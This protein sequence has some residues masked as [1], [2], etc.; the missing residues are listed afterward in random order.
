MKISSLTPR[1]ILSS[2]IAALLGLHLAPAVHA[3]TL[4]WDNG[5]A[6]GNWNT[7]DTNWTGSIWNNATPDNAIFNNI[8]GTVTLTQAITGGTLTY[9]NG[10]SPSGAHELILTGSN[11]SLASIL[12][13]GGYN[14][15]LGNGG[16]DSIG[17]AYNQRLRL[18]NITVATSGNATARRGM[19]YLNNATL[20]VGG[21]I[22]CADA[23]NVFREDNSTVTATGGIDLSIIASQV[24]LYGGTV[25]TPFVKVGNAAFNGTGGLFM[26]GGVTLVPTGASSDYLAVFNNGDVNNRAGATITSGGMTIDTAYAVTVATSLGGSGSLAKSGNGSLTLTNNNSYT[27]GTTVNSGV[28]EVS[29]SSGGNG[30]IRGTATVNAGGELRFTGGDGTGFGYNGGNRIDT[31]NINGGLVHSVGSA[32]L[33]NGVNVN[34]T[35]GELRVTSGTVQWNYVNVT[36]AASAST[37]LINAAINFRGDGGFTNSI[38]NVADGAAATDLEVTGPIT[39]S[40]GTVGLTKNGPGTMKLTGANSYSG[41]T[42]I[43]DGTLEI[44]G[45]AG[46]LGSGGVTNYAALLFNRSTALTVGNVISGS[47]SVT[48]SGAGTITLTGANS[49][50]GTTTINVGTTLE[51]GGSA[52]SLGSG[53][54]VNDGA[55][56]FNR[57][58]ALSDGNAISGTGSVTQSGAGIT[59]LSGT[60]TYTGAT[61]VTA[62]GLDLIGSLTSN[63]TVSGG[64]LSGEGSTTGSLTLTGAST[65]GFDPTTGTYLSAASV[66]AT[67]GTVTLVPAISTLG[68]GIVV[69]EAVGGITGV[70]GT[71]FVFTG[72]GTSYLN[73]GNTQLLFD[74]TPGSVVWTGDDGT[75]PT[76]WDV[77]TTGNWTLGGNPDL[78][79]TG[80]SVTFDDT[81]TSFNVAVQGASLTPGGV[82]FDN[83]TAYTVSGGAIAGAGGLTKNNTGTVTIKSAQTF[84]GATVINAGTLQLGDG[85]G[86]ND[87]SL[88]TSGITNDGTLAYNLNGNQTVGYAISGTGALTK[89]GAG[90][91][92]LT[93]ANS[94]T[95][96]TTVSGGVL[97]AGIASAFGDSSGA[98]SVASGGSLDVNAQQLDG[99]TQNIQIAGSGSDAALGALGNH[100]A[101]NLNAVRGLTLTGNASIGGNGGRWDIGRLDW[102]ADPNNTVNHING[103][104]FVLTKVGSSELG[105][106]CG[107][108]NL[109]GFVLNAGTIVPH[110]NTAF[111]TAP[112]TINAGLFK[113]WAGLTLANNFTLN[114]GTIGTDAGFNDTYTG[115]FAINAAVTFNP[116]N[117]NI[118]LTGAVDGAGNLNKTGSSRLILSGNNTQTGTL[119]VSG[120]HVQFASGTGNAT[121]GNVE[122]LNPGSFLLMN[123]PNQFGPN[124]GLLFNSSGGH[125]EF[126]LYGNNQTIASLAS[127]N[128]FAVVQNSHG[129]F[130][131]A[132][133]S[134]TLTVNQSTDTTYYGVFRDN[135][136]NDAFTL[137]L[138]K[139]G[140][141]KLTLATNASHTGGTTV[142]GGVLEVAGSSGG[143]GYIR[144]TATVNVGGELRFSGGDGTGFGYNNGNRIDTLNILGGLVHSTTTAH[145]FNGVNVNMTGGEL[146]VS[147][148]NIQW[149]FVTVTTAASASTALI[150]GALNFRG[151]GGFSSSIFNV[152]D[153]A[154]AADLEVNGPI[155]QLN[156]NVGLTKN[157]TGTMVLS[158]ANSYGGQ[159]QINAG[160]LLVTNSTGLGVGGH[161]GTTMTFIQDGAT[162]ALQGGISLDEHFHVWGAGVGGL[163]A[164]RSISGNN[165]LTNAPGGGPGYALRSDT[166]VGVEAD[167]LTVSGFY[168]GDAGSYGLIKIGAGTLTLTAASTYT[169]TTTVSGGTLELA[170]VNAVQAS[171]LDT[172]T[173][174]AQSVTFTVA[175]TNT[176]NLGGLS[177]ADDLNAG[178]NSLSVGGNNASTTYTGNGTAATFTK[179]GT[180]TLDLNGTTQAFGTLAAND[181]TTNVNG[182]LGSGTSVVTVTDTV[183]GAATKLRFGTVSQ[184]LGSLTI[185]AGATVVFTS[186]TASGSFSSG[187]KG[188]G[189]GGSAVVPEPGTLGLLLVGALGALGRRRQS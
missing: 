13:W 19:I 28:L 52:G 127:T 113:T 107:A 43:N 96:A 86:G 21:T 171:T 42:R 189:L 73:G 33:F 151:D 136:G 97:K 68:T 31:L 37:A 103:G 167:T 177:G 106:L 17:E 78:F 137:A 47:G 18:E 98:I 142:N 170:H 116:G 51:V 176:Y 65:L 39:Q 186:G 46:T 85:T 25:T 155:S 63:V 40:G 162:L 1:V 175:G 70:P 54:V 147:S 184:T 66:N 99:Y 50:L 83:T 114:G 164:V 2:T 140:S 121:H 168:N 3:A 153:G 69:L 48:Q 181:G 20:N 71:N 72:R 15:S 36:T 24:E 29:G 45:A 156:G 166:T 126:A 23:W 132:S 187:G 60:S 139:T 38:F 91:L 109:A 118:T 81:A 119:Y 157:G 169:G 146:R 80:D 89:S 41:T 123:A 27:G 76:F 6:T 95:G 141:G 161:N 173:A 4:T 135:T 133:A 154:A 5:A 125:N 174:G 90:T 179:V 122:L 58:T 163:G 104:G 108:T 178:T 150:N 84:T 62:G 30:Y 124:S 22:N 87:G 160:T 172:G 93:A 134:S 101:S 67:G 12:S 100:G 112:I 129:G 59:T 158:G 64:G 35:G 75:N 34:M 148:G 138:E 149:N 53:G 77:N 56:V 44:G 14:P 9:N 55:L 185:G 57:S 131:A 7:T 117:G 49:Y 79:L 10:G 165:A 102:N 128:G 130:G 152:A 183:G 111:G 74:F 16:V 11:L 32:H 105:L 145:L 8:N 144:G 26:G 88:T 180:G 94:Y 120:G 188:A 61:S 92:T 115:S 110:E 182:T 143:N 82:T 159:T